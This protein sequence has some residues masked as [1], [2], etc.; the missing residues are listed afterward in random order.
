[1]QIILSNSIFLIKSVCLQDIANH[2]M[3]VRKVRVSLHH[4]FGSPVAAGNGGG[5]EQTFPLIYTGVGIWGGR[6]QIS[7]G[8]CS[9]AEFF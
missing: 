3:S 4:M 6:E 2:I 8:I 1:M 9:S 5:K 7:R